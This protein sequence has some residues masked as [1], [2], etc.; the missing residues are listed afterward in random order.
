MNLDLERGTP[1]QRMGGVMDTD[2]N[3]AMLS[4]LQLGANEACAVIGV[5]V[6]EGAFD[7]ELAFVRGH[8][9]EF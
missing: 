6:V 2:R 5:G 3:F 8:C 1:G 7:D 4:G 9:P